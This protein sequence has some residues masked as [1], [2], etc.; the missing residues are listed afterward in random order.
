[1]AS[2]IGY[3]AQVFPHLTMTFVYRE[4]MALRS[5]G[6]DVETFATWQPKITE[7]SEEAKP[8]VQDTFYIF[9]L[10]WLQFFLSHVVFL[11]TRPRRYLS[12]LWFCLTRY[13]SSFKN[14]WRTTMHF[15]QAVYL[16]QA[17][18]RSHIQHLH[19]HFALNA[20]TLAMVISR[21]SDISFSFT[22]HANDIFANPIL[23]PEKIK[24]AQFVIVI[25]EFN[26]K[27]L[28]TIV[29]DHVI[30]QKTHVVHCG[31]DVTAFAPPSKVIHDQP[32]MLAVGR[33]VEKKGYPHL[34][35]ACKVLV[36]QGYRF[37]CLIIGGGPEEQRL[38]QLVID[39][40]LEDYVR[41]EGVVFQEKM[42][43][44]LSR[45]DICVLPCVVASDQDMDGIPNTLME[46]MAMEIPVVSTTISGIP[47]L[48]EHEKTGLLVPPENEEALAEALARL[49]DDD[50][51][52]R[53][54]GTAGRK[55]V[56]AEFEI[57]KNSRVLLDIFN[58]YLD[59]ELNLNPELSQA[60]L[61]SSLSKDM[62]I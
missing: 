36:Q 33:L 27:F 17:V 30:A 38:Q 24:A 44:Y 34:I 61:S 18:E 58:M 11:F 4:V 14:R 43:D 20:T 37:E 5:F 50:T 15:A 8:L 45:A 26:R 48:I 51:L 22:A 16:A 23:L 47:E 3:L 57:E 12:T 49:L 2:K 21:L 7:L 41:L 29:P 19:V 32:L 59:N 10:N 13:H 1:M 42:K 46:A 39:H 54:L 40:R 55:K 6:L 53:V 31:I 28:Q 9:P 35:R 56:V 62:Y 25:S 60:E 52:R